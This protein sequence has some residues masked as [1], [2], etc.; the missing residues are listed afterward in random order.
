MY[1]KWPYVTTRIKRYLLLR[2]LYREM[3]ATGLLK[4]VTPSH[5][6]F[7][8]QVVATKHPD[9]G[10]FRALIKPLLAYVRWR[11]ARVRVQLRS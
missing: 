8:A 6:L 5:R 7:H 2:N 3:D 1:H 9:V 11:L 4:S 10:M